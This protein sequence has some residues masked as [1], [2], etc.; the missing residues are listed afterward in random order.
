M[1]LVVGGAFQGKLEFGKTLAKGGETARCGLTPWEELWKYPVICDFQECVRELILDGQDVNGFVEEL[2][3]KD[4][5]AVI[6][7]DEI[8]CGIVPIDRRDREY[9]EAVGLAGQLLAARARKVYRVVCG[10]GTQ[11]K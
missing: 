5:E 9:R 1:I 8:G 10:I 4:S 11:I 6:I 3:R 7:M 2:L